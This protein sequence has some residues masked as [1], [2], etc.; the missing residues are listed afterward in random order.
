MKATDLR[1][2]NL[3][4]DAGEV[5]FV[6]GIG[7]S[8]VIIST[9]T[10]D[11]VRKYSELKPIPL[12]EDW[13]LKFGFEKYQW[14]DDC[15]YIPFL[16]RHLMARLYNGKW[17]I[18]KTKVTIANSNQQ[19]TGSVDIVDKGLIQYVHQLQNLY[20]ALTGEELTIK[21]P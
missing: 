1:M 5:L 4:D 17:H 15:A 12:T 18:F 21:E 14:C 7:I 9:A 10:N 6:S 20:Y 3:F 8:N 2:G 16:G 19:Y 13:L 11:S